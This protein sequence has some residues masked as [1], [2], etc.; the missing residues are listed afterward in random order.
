MAVIAFVDMLQLDH[1]VYYSLLNKKTFI[2][3]MKVKA[4]HHLSG[5]P[6]GIGTGSLARGCRS[7]LGPVPP[8]LVMKRYEIL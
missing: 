7:F 6:A 4:A 8:L 1:L 5:N 2:P 3:K